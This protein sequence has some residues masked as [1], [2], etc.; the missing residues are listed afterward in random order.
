MLQLGHPLADGT[1]HV[2][3]TL[4]ALPERL[5]R[6]RVNRVQYQGLL[7]PSAAW[8]PEVVPLSA[9]KAKADARVLACP[10]CGGRLR[11]VALIEASA[12]ARVDP[13]APGPARR[14]AV[15]GVG[16]STAVITDDARPFVVLPPAES[17]CT[18]PLPRRVPSGDVP[19]MRGTRWCGSGQHLA[20]G[21]GGW[22]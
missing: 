7:A 15:A 12:V 17:V 2:A 9:Q 16:A 21:I 4:T 3:F 8:R 5:A 22:S 13:P 19:R 14:R 6:P 11:L 1:T 10:R 18:A 20:E